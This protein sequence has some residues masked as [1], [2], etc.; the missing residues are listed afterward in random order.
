VVYY[1][2]VAVVS[3]EESATGRQVWDMLKTFRAEIIAGTP[4]GDYVV[5]FPDSGPEPQRY[6]TL[7]DELNRTPGVALAYPTVYSQDIIMHRR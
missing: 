1:R 5:R 2:T 4:T 7:L 3:F 6:L